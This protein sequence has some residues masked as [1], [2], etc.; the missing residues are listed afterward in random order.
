MALP[1]DHAIHLASSGQCVPADIDSPVIIP[2]SEM[3]E[4]T[5]YRSAAT[6]PVT[7]A[8][9]RPP[10]WERRPSHSSTTHHD[11]P[12]SPTRGH[13]S[14]PDSPTR[15]SRSFSKMS[16]D[17]ELPFP[18]SK[19]KAKWGLPRA[20][21]SPRRLALYLLGTTILLALLQL[22]YFGSMDLKLAGLR[23]RWSRNVV[24][25][26]G[27]GKCQFWST[28]DAYKR[29]LDRLRAMFPSDST[30][31][32]RDRTHSHHGHLYSSTGHLLI[33]DRPDAP[34]P[35]PTLLGLGEKRWEEL[36][37]RQSRTLEEAVQEYTRRYG[38]NPPKGFDV[39][40]DYAMLHDLVLP[41][42]YDRINLD[43]APFFALPRDEMRRRMEMVE[44][45]KETFTLIIRGG[46]VDIEILD[47]GGLE[48][49][50][51]M[52]RAQSTAQ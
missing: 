29:D 3:T 40:W 32:P 19:P 41:D 44:Q 45:M 34:H 20:I 13:R 6:P 22:G 52:P 7:P 1:S 14:L 9:E 51:T 24:E 49:G 48:W 42:E 10:P 26:I 35:I 12:E 11:Y 27:D 28:M 2:K 30:S 31:H 38:R 18:L 37:S 21:K 46:N 17:R 47:E 15:R 8:K 39:W 33:S 16:R 25:D 4:R 23:S 36:L 5:P 43:L 50:G